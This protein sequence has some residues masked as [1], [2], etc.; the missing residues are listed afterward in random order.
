MVSYDFANV[1]QVRESSVNQNS[2]PS[3]SHL[4]SIKHAGT[5]EIIINIAY[6]ERLRKLGEKSYQYIQIIDRENRED[7]TSGIQ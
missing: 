7:I 1:T 3:N 6:K 2:I 4:Q 5:C